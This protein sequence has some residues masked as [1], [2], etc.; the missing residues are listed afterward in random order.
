MDFDNLENRYANAVSTVDVGVAPNE[1]VAEALLRKYEQAT[2]PYR[3]SGWDTD[4]DGNRR[5]Y[6]QFHMTV[7]C[8]LREVFLSEEYDCQKHEHAPVSAHGLCLSCGMI[9]R[10]IRKEGG[11][12]E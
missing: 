3:Y 1:E 10:E 6:P 5:L 7:L 4:Y 8:N 11:D 12:D 2:E 9:M